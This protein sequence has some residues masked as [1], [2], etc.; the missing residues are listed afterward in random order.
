VARDGSDANPAAC[1]A[2]VRPDDPRR[3][4]GLKDVINVQRDLG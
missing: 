1:W 3:I 2:G 4:E